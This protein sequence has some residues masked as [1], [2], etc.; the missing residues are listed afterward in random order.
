MSGVFLPVN[1]LL[2][3]HWLYLPSVGCFAWWVHTLLTKG[4]PPGKAPIGLF[5]CGLCALFFAMRTYRQSLY[6]QDPISFYEHI[7]A[8]DQ[9][10]PRIQ[11]NLGMAYASHGRIQEAVT[12]YEQAIR[13]SDIYPQT[14]F[15]LGVLCFH[16]K[17]FDLAEVHL[18]RSIELNPLFF[19]SHQALF[20]LYNALGLNE[21]AHVHKTLYETLVKNLVEHPSQTQI[22]P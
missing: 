7:L 2:L 18:K 6:W 19:Q 14:R 3:E 1:S 21:Q 10:S 9:S 16:Q 4:C 13:L 11:N 22:T 8:Y 15:N 5:I 20:Q 12:A 17:R